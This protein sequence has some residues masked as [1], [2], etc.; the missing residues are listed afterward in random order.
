MSAYG[1]DV[2]GMFRRLVVVCRYIGDDDVDEYFSLYD[3]ECD[4]FR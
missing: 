2:I 1:D 4:D 3:R